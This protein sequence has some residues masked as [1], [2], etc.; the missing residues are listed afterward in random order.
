M[1]HHISLLYFP[2]EFMPVKIWSVLCL[3]SFV[4]LN[5]SKSMSLTNVFICNLQGLKSQ[6]A[7]LMYG[8]L[9]IVIA[10]LENFNEL[11]Q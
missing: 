2:F 4:L 1:K 10:L 8:Q 11:N 5:I 3:F 6:V 9:L 7:E